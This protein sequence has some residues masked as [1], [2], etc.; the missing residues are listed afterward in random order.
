MENSPFVTKPTKKTFEEAVD[1]LKENAGKA[2]FFVTAEH[3][4]HDTFKKNNLEWER[5]YT[6][7]SICNPLKSHHALSMN[8]KMGC[9][10]PKNIV[11]YEDKKG[12]VNIMMMK[13]DPE[14]MKTLFPE[15]NID[16]MS[17][18]VGSTLINIIDQS[19]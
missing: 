10:M 15:L 9:F 3:R 11:V 17:K 18:E 8:D 7:I 13:G 14:K 1:A 19:I 5:N 16:Q 4:M 6:I 2:G 12:T